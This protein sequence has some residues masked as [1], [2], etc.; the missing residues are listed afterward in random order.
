M[1]DRGKT[2]LYISL[3]INKQNGGAYMLKSRHIHT[4]FS[5]LLLGF[6]CHA[7]A[8]CYDPPKPFMDWSGCDKRGL[9]LAG[10]NLQGAN[11]T[12]AE[13]QGAYLKS[14]NFGGAVWVDGRTCAQESQDGCNQGVHR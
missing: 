8:G 11:L 14:A 10:A 12:N 2:L 13:L 1:W 5:P 3:G 6:A 4:L 7:N 9:D